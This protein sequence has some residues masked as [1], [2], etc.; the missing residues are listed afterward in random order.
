MISR[1]E[2]LAVYAQGPEA[3]VTL[4][5]ALLATQAAEVAALTARI[6]ALEDR[7]A[8]DSHN[9]HLPPSRDLPPAPKSLR[10]PSGRKPGGQPGHQGTTLAWST[11]P[12]HTIVQRPSACAHCGASLATATVVRTER[13]QVVDLPPLRLAT[14]EQV[15]EQRRCAGCGAVTAG[16]FPPEARGRVSYGPR[17]RGL[18]VYLHAFQLLPY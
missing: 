11:H 2:I 17:L 4:V 1:D 6:Q 8:K 14:P 18:A 7:L 3:V 10:R 12:D 5:E 13:R 15:V 16:I 9:S